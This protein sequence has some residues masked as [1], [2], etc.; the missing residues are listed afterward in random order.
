MVDSK[1][2]STLYRQHAAEVERLKA[3]V[4]AAAAA[5]GRTVRIEV[6]H[7]DSRGGHIVI[8]DSSGDEVAISNR[9]M[10]LLVASG[11]AGTLETTRAVSKEFVHR[12]PDA[13]D[14]TCG[15]N[16]AK[17]T[18]GIV[19]RGMYD[20]TQAPWVPWV[21][22][23]DTMKQVVDIEECGIRTT[24]AAQIGDLEGGVVVEIE[25]LRHGWDVRTSSMEDTVHDRAIPRAFAVVSE[26]DGNGV[27]VSVTCPK[28]TPFRW[29]V[30]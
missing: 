7:D 2:L 1:A 5:T 28:D 11:V 13:A 30:I 19:L 21:E 4:T 23:A 12:L 15:W 14:P 8:T 27:R 17:S 22:I 18:Y 6:N 24:L 25:Q 26:P 3:V 16:E 29:V 20:D 10:A 9:L